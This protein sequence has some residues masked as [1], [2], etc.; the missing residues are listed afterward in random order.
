VGAFSI[1]I[2]VL[3]ALGILAL[4]LFGI[5]AFWE[6]RADF[7]TSWLCLLLGLGLIGLG[8]Y[9]DSAFGFIADLMGIPLFLI[10]I[11]MVKSGDDK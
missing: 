7:I 10:G 11:W 2:I 9:L 3:I 1:A 4:I 6:K 5:S 8:I